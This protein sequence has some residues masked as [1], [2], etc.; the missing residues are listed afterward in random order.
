MREGACDLQNRVKRP[1]FPPLDASGSEWSSKPQAYAA[2]R[3][4][5]ASRPL[6]VSRIPMAEVSVA[7]RRL[8]IMQLL[9]EHGHASVSKLSERFGVS[10]VTVRKDLSALEEDHV[11]VRTHGGAVL[12]EHFQFDLPFR[13]QS[14]RH[15]EEKA[16]IGQAAAGRV[17]DHDTLILTVGS[18]TAQVARHLSEKKGLTVLTNAIRIV[19][20][21]LGH[22][23]VELLLLGGHLSPATASTAGPYAEQMLRDHSFRK[24]FLAADGLDLDYGLTTTSTG[25]AHLHR[26]MIEVAEEVIVVSDASKFGRRALNRVCGLDDVDVLI[27]DDRASERDVRHLEDLGVEVWAV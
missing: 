11:V 24:L 9:K 6:Y 19:Y 27:T 4:S 22:M 26:L 15:A 3:H 1:I 18:T 23:E 20:D 12:A 8:R 2:S 16:R 21:L 10:E 7:E 13:E 25:E 17:T 5:P 14:I